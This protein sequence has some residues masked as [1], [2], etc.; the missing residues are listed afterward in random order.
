MS[1]RFFEQILF[2]K[3]KQIGK[4]FQFSNLINRTKWLKKAGRFDDRDGRNFRV[5]I[6]RILQMCS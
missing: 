1:D 3:S 5:K 4:N 6:W 2:Y